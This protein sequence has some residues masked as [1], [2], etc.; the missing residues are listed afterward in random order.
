MRRRS[1]LAGTAALACGRPRRVEPGFGETRDTVAALLDAWRE[2][3]PVVGLSIA[4]VDRGELAWATGFGMADREARQP[5]TADTVYAIGSLTKIYTAL[6]AVR[7]AQAGRLDLEAPLQRHLPQLRALGS[8][9]IRLRQLLCHRSGLVSDWHRGSLGARP[10][11]WR[12]VADEVAE[13]PLLAAPDSWYA[14]SN[15]GYTLMGHVLDDM[16]D[17][18][19]QEHVLDVARLALGGSGLGFDPPPGMAASYCAGQREHEPRLRLQPAAGMFGSVL[20]LVPL[21]RWLLAGEGAAAAMLTP[22]SAGPLDFDERWGLGLALQH[23]GLAHAGRVAWHT[24]RTFGHRAALFALPDRGLGVAVLANFREAG[25]VE[26]LAAFA[27]Q[28]ALLER[29][30]LDLPPSA[31]DAEARPRAPFD[32][33]ALQA[34]VGRYAHEFDVVRLAVERGGLVS[35]AEIGKTALIPAAGGGFHSADNPDAHVTIAERAGHHVVTSTVRGVETRIG[36]RCPFEHVPEDWLRRVGRYTVDAGPDEVVAFKAAHLTAV[37]G[38]LELRLE[39]PQAFATSSTLA[40]YALIVTGPH[41][42]RTFGVG[43]G[44]GQRVAAFDGPEGPEL[45]W[46]GYRLLRSDA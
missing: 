27:L 9:A 11:D 37:E 32:P 25:G 45:A 8:D 4:L 10:P 29:D 21:L 15:V 24:G 42:A 22:Q 5:A 43:R 33:A 34:H 18:P 13:E 17:K 3:M 36:V 1:F 20:D 40:R 44:K 16:S 41:E 35:R 12:R 14:Y 30:G 23:V 46:A 7:A 38:G 6:A 28:T 31:G 19:Y 26:D 39:L 2:K